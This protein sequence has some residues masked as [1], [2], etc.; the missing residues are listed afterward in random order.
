MDGKP[1]WKLKDD[2]QSPRLLEDLM[3]SQAE[4]LGQV[5]RDP[6]IG[7]GNDGP[8]DV[9]KDLADALRNSSA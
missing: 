7:R 8:D 6:D 4:D 9:I 2:L 1:L 3:Q 5:K